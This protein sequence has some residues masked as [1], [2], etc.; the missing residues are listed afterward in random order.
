MRAAQLRVNSAS[1]VSM[2]AAVNKVFQMAQSRV[3]RVTGALAS[4]GRTAKSGNQYTLRRT[5]GYGD[6]TINPTTGRAT[7]S[8]AVRVHEVFDVAHPGSY[9][10]LETSLREYGQAS[11]ITDLAASIRGHL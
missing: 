1:A 7:A 4:S 2:D 5:I 9:K 8:Y 11:F 3:P 6:S 10:W